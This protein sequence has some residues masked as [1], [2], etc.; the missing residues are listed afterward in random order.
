MRFEVSIGE[1]RRDGLLKIVS[2]R[3]YHTQAEAERAAEAYRARPQI[4]HVAVRD[5]KRDYQDPAAIVFRIADVSAKGYANALRWEFR[6]A[7]GADWCGRAV[8]G[9]VA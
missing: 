2:I 8:V 3:T 6:A 5:K 4:F 7:H 9:D 1:Y